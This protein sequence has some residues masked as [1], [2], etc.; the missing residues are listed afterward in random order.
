M[1]ELQVPGI[2]GMNQDALDSRL[3]NEVRLL[4]NGRNFRSNDGRDGTVRNIL[5]TVIGMDDANFSANARVIGH[6]KYSENNSILA[7][8]YDTGS[9]NGNSII[10]YFPET[11]TYTLIL[12]EQ[13][14]PVL[15]FSP[16]HIIRGAYVIDGKLYWNDAYNSPRKINIQ[17]AKL[18]TSGDLTNGYSVV[19]K[20]T[21]ELIKYPPLYQMY[22]HYDTVVIKNPV[23]G[24]GTISNSAG[25]ATVTGVSTTFTTT[26]EVGQYIKIGGKAYQVKTIPSDTSMTTEVITDANTAV[27]YWYGEYMKGN[28]LRGKLFQFKYA[29]IYDDDELSVPSQVS[30][31]AIPLTSDM[32][33]SGEIVGD[34]QKNNCIKFFISIGHST[35]K[36]IV[37]YAR[38][39]NLGMWGIV[40]TLNRSDVKGMLS[41][42]GTFT[43]SFYNDRV[44]EIAD[45]LKVDEPYHAVPLLSDELGYIHSNQILLA[46][47]TEGKNN[48]TTDCELT[49]SLNNIV[50]VE[51]GTQINR[52]SVVE[53][54]Y[55]S[56][57]FEGE[58]IIGLN[59]LP[60]INSIVEITLVVPVGNINAGEVQVY[61]LFIGA[62]EAGSET[63]WISA[64][65]NAIN[66]H[67]PSVTASS[68]S[69]ADSLLVWS[70]NAPYFSLMVIEFS[71]SAGVF[72]SYGGFKTG[73]TESFGLIYYD[74]AAR[75]TFV[76]KAGEIYL[77]TLPELIVAGVTPAPLQSNVYY[78]NWS[79]NH[80][81]PNW[82]TKYQWCRQLNK[83]LYYFQQYI[84]GGITDGAA[85]SADKS[86]IDI[87]PLNLHRSQY[88]GLDYS[89]PS[90][91]IAA[92]SWEKGDRIRFITQ[93]KVD[94]SGVE[95][96]GDLFTEVMDYEILGYELTTPPVASTDPPQTQTNS[97]LV[98]KIDLSTHSPNLTVT[99]AGKNCLV[100]IYRPLKAQ[101]NLSY[102]E[103]GEL[104]DIVGAY[105]SGPTQIQTAT[106]PAT[107]TFVNGD[108]Y[109]VPTVFS[110]NMGTVI[111]APHINVIESPSASNF[112]DLQDYN[113]GRV[114]IPDENAKQKKVLS[115]RASD[116]Y[117]ENTHVNGLSAFYAGKDLF[118]S[119]EFGQDIIGLKE[120][121]FSLK[122]LQSRKITTFFVGRQG[123][124]ISS[125]AT[126]QI[127]A[128]SKDVLS[129]KSPSQEMYGCVNPE[130]V[131]LVN[132]SLYFADIRN[133]AII[134]DSNN[135]MVDITVYGLHSTFNNLFESL[136]GMDSNRIMASF[137]PL[138][139]EVGF[140]FVG[141]NAG[142]ET[143]LG[144]YYFDDIEDEWTQKWD[145]QEAG[146]CP[147][148][149]ADIN[150]SYISFVG[151][152]IWLHE[153]GA[154]NLIYGSQL[155][156]TIEMIFNANA[157]N[158][159]LYKTLEIE[160]IGIWSCP[161][162]GDVL[163]EAKNSNIQRDQKSRLVVAKFK[164]VKGVMIAPFMKDMN[165]QNGANKIFNLMNG[166]DLKGNI[167]SLRLTNNDT[168]EAVLDT[169]VVT[170]QI[171]GI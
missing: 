144:T 107:G 160:G 48:L 162:E 120:K 82:A 32:D 16:D 104:F 103:M 49:H 38:E 40:E 134:R 65:Q 89:F 75:S 127:Q 81:P 25:G 165:T 149:F 87:S 158:S 27:Q 51:K 44:I 141:I 168:S 17:R 161:N 73:V 90:S 117:F 159:K 112:Y 155:P 47:N 71:S 35:V 116:V 76:Q 55:L 93:E 36:K 115:I 15:N 102:Y 22:P 83:T 98:Q 135:G 37:V 86:L 67:F 106:Q 169:V 50:P 171:L 23:L 113:I 33:Y 80:L 129:T 131:L 110:V 4:H 145:Y 31:L 150:Q 97:L 121:G 26:F 1:R 5:G 142:V 30:K 132:G 14:T 153:K 53:T 24:G 66:T 92:Y 95:G 154:R 105:H 59:I 61:D 8:I 57:T 18:F 152:K 136:K 163:I 68:S 166:H 39:G 119:A 100:E 7:F 56:E 85:D 130:S 137:N 12:K 63:S 52:W 125:D 99:N 54:P 20:Q 19:D 151:K 167:L 84:I 58:L 64:L 10:E 148:G 156:I 43:Y 123:L 124:Q 88:N 77:P 164:N 140:T 157:G 122:V 34:L 2:Y 101:D 118:V 126:S 45:Q 133:G 70:T 109:I 114:S 170:S 139:K 46:G 13:T 41:D 94:F 9:V 11:N 69:V 147:M 128:T 143:D 42:F 6:A 96:L 79:I 29:Y 138:I 78:I 62:G 60:L 146:L 3:H 91:W 111:A 74:E 28:N 72:H 21:I 108:V